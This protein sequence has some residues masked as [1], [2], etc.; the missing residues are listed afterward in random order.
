MR[1][2]YPDPRLLL[3]ALAALVLAMLVAAAPTAVSDLDLLSGTGP[4]ASPPAEVTSTPAA[5]PR[6]GPEQPPAWVTDPLASP[7]ERF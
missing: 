2:T 6:V 4:S 1:A 7:L 3:A 5:G